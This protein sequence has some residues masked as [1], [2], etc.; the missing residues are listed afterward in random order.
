LFNEYT[1][2]PQLVTQIARQPADVYA[3]PRYLC[4]HS[5]HC[6]GFVVFTD[7]SSH[8]AGFFF[9]IRPIQFEYT[10]D[11]DLT[12]EYAVTEI[13][14]NSN[15]ARRHDL[16]VESRYHLHQVPSSFAVRDSARV[17]RIQP[18]QFTADVFLLERNYGFPC[19]DTRLDWTF[20]LLKN[21]AARQ[22]VNQRVAH[23]LSS[24]GADPALVQAMTWSAASQDLIRLDNRHDLFVVDPDTSAVTFPYR[25]FLSI[26]LRREL[27]ADIAQ[28][29][30]L[31]STLGGGLN[32]ALNLSLHLPMA[33][34]GAPSISQLLNVWLPS[35]DL[36][37]RA[38]LD[39]NL[40]RLLHPQFLTLRWT[41]PRFQDSQGNNEPASTTTTMDDFTTLDS[42]TGTGGQDPNFV[43][44]SNYVDL[45]PTTIRIYAG[46]FRQ[47]IAYFAWRDWIVF[48][49]RT[50]GVNRANINS[51]CVW[52]T[53]L[54]FEGNAGP[55]LPYCSVNRCPF[56]PI[57]TWSWT[58]SKQLIQESPQ[59]VWDVHALYPNPP[60]SA[61]PIDRIRNIPCNNDMGWCG[62]DGTCQCYPF[63]N[64]KTP[65]TKNV[66]QN[67]QI[68]TPRV[69]KIQACQLDVRGPCLNGDR[70]INNVCSAHG[71]CVGSFIGNKQSASCECGRFPIDPLVAFP[72]NTR[73]DA[74][75]P[76]PTCN[77]RDPPLKWEENG[78]VADS[79]GGSS[80]CNIPAPGCRNPGA[81]VQRPTQGYQL[82]NSYSCVLPRLQNG[83]GLQFGRC[84][85]NG[86]LDQYGEKV[87]TCL[88]DDGHYGSQ[89]EYPTLNGG[90]F[91]LDLDKFLV[92]SQNVR[93]LRT[94]CVWNA[95]L[96]QFEPVSY[97]NMPIEFMIG[98]VPIVC[99]GIK[100]S[101]HGQCIHEHMDQPNLE[102]LSPSG[103]DAFY[104]YIGSFPTPSEVNFTNVVKQRL[105]AQHCVC[106]KGWTGRYCNISV[107]DPPCV[108]GE[109]TTKYV[110]KLKISYCKCFVSPQSGLPLA[111][112]PTCN[113]AICAG[114]GTIAQYTTVDQSTYRYCNCT[115][116]YFQG[117]DNTKVC[118]LYCDGRLQRLNTNTLTPI[119]A[120]RCICVN[121]QTHRETLCNG[122]DVTVS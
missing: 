115:A 34:F 98:Q 93:S 92:S 25:K 56:A 46:R 11:P 86:S 80:F 53:P 2:Y 12:D 47:L 40:S 97:S 65:M 24:L 43:Y 88:C 81:Y 102:K 122:V 5:P 69:L 100:C 121:P 108:H 117:A 99:G 70:G 49:T 112:G 106:D 114:R 10:L 41:I 94:Q 8:T 119:P 32:L 55:G 39:T 90:C 63:S 30:L 9:S 42:N 3:Q 52:N 45:P 59:V 7:I 13:L 27:L 84:I 33:G 75:R 17:R 36:A 20:Y 29:A 28:G 61:L 58:P 66:I 54:W 38:A 105:L 51:Y 79:T 57:A 19:T 109:C 91:D 96:T 64:V 107:C 23:H 50:R 6:H 111:T 15:V 14:V 110:D 60:E 78:W 118:N 103:Q 101:G 74:V 35:T 87:W 72:P 37:V 68:Q 95:H 48:G 44:L 21:T 89:C 67:N 16:D 116:P 85:T 104:Q 73:C 76:T 1:I 4:S 22:R 83:T 71:E 18:F 31:N 26:D 113:D 62:L 82:G 77:R 120:Y